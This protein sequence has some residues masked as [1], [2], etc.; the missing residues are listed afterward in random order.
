MS[1]PSIRRI[2]AQWCVCGGICTA[3]RKRTVLDAAVA[4]VL[5]Q[6]TS[7]T[8]SERGTSLPLQPRLE[9]TTS[10]PDLTESGRCAT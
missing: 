4:L 1:C 3:G 9:P 2:G 5:S 6:N 8:N 10:V 7:N